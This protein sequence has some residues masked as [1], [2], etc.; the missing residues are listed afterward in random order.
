MLKIGLICCFLFFLFFII[1]V[2]YGKCIDL[3]L[4]RESRIYTRHK[5][6]QEL[7]LSGGERVGGAQIARLSGC[8]RDDHVY[9]MMAGAGRPS[10]FQ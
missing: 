6:K 8:I 2:F 3:T 4:F 10:L 7:R 9:V 1:F 5:Q